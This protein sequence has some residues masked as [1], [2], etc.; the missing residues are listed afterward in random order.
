VSA[1]PDQKF[2]TEQEDVKIKNQESALSATDPEDSD[3]D[4]SQNRSVA[5]EMETLVAECIYPGVQWTIESLFRVSNLIAPALK[6]WNPST[7][8]EFNK[9]KRVIAPE[10]LKLYNVPIFPKKS[11][12]PNADAGD[13]D[14]EKNGNFKSGVEDQ[15]VHEASIQ[16]LEKST[17]SVPNT[18]RSS[19]SKNPSMPQ[20]REIIMDKK[21]YYENSW[22]RLNATDHSGSNKGLTPFQSQKLKESKTRS[23]KKVDQQKSISSSSLNVESSNITPQKRLLP[24]SRIFPRN[25]N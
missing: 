6:G 14:Y 12:S 9:R 24:I 16:I 1:S 20:K 11:I 4:K 7:F 3:T 5:T 15:D 18:R 19:F 23:Q 17:E 2:L 21:G 8:V 22:Y 25:G 13:Y 10:I